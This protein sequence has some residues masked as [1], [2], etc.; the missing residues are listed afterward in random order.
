[1]SSNSEIQ[2]PRN[3]TT[4]STSVVQPGSSTPRVPQ[5]PPLP[6]RRPLLCPSPPPVPLPPFSPLAPV[7]EI[8][9][10]PVQV[11]PFVTPNTSPTRLGSVIQCPDSCSHT[12]ASLPNIPSLSQQLL[13]PSYQLGD[14]LR[15]RFAAT[16]TPGSSRPLLVSTSVSSFEPEADSSE[17]EHVISCDNTDKTAI[18]QEYLGHSMSS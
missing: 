4:P 6:P 15:S 10:P 18:E 13:K 14:K 8:P 16:V 1:M 7:E 9:V 3:I 2:P 17:T 5:P 12:S 11:D